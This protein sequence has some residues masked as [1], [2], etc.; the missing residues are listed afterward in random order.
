MRDAMP[1]TGQARAHVIT[2]RTC[3]L[4]LP[5]LVFLGLGVAGEDAEEPHGGVDVVGVDGH[6]GAV[7]DEAALR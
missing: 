5:L 3:A 7:E 4:V 1:R 6:L 2:S